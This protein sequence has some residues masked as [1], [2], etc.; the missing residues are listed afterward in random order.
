MLGTSLEHNE[1]LVFVVSSCPTGISLTGCDI[2]QYTS[3][4]ESGPKQGRQIKHFTGHPGH[5]AVFVGFLSFNMPKQFQESKLFTSRDLRKM[6]RSRL[7]SKIGTNHFGP[8]RSLH[9]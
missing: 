2:I 3:H 5:P 7:H 4:S 1:S 8:P 9:F 6:D